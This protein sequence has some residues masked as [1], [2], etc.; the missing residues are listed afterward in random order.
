MTRVL[1]ID[2]SSTCTGWAVLDG[3]NPA[4]LIDGGLI[5]PDRG[6]SSL[7]RIQ[8]TVDDVLH[9]LPEYQ[10]DRLVIEIPSGKAGTGS[11]R[12]AKSALAIY[13]L[14]VGAVW[15]GCRAAF[16]GPVAAVDERTWIH[17][18]KERRALAIEAYYPGRYRMSTDKGLDLADAI[19]LG[20]WYLQQATTPRDT[21]NKR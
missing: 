14:A 2:P 6:A 16:S 20:R 19:G 13:G 10:P 9:L 4:D 17:A 18:S 15:Q 5:R 12:G 21:E 11:K 7:L 1:A 8:E 3:L